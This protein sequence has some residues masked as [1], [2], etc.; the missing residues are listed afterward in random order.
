MSKFLHLLFVLALLS[1]WITGTCQNAVLKG[2]VTEKGGTETLP[3]ANVSIASSGVVTDFDGTFMVSVPAGTYTVKISYVGYQP[4]EFAVT[5]RAG[6]T[7]TRDAE[8]E[9]ET[10]ILKTATVTSGKFARPLSEET[11]SL[12]V[13]RPGLM[14]S[15]GK[16]SLEDALEK[17]PGVTII[18]GQ[19]NIRG[20]SGF[21][22]GAGSRVLL[23]VD[24]IPILQADA[25]YPNW[26][27]VPVENIAQ[28]EVLK[29]A[30]SALYG[31]SAL[32]GIINVRTAFAKSEPE[33]GGA[34]W[35]TT[36]FSPKDKSLK[37]WG[38]NDTLPTPFTYGANFYHRQRFQKLDLV[39]GG[40]YQNEQSFN[41]DTYNEYGRLNFATRYRFSERLSAG[42][43]GNFNRGNSGSFFY[44]RDL[45]RRF[46]GDTTTLGD[47]NRFRYNLDPFLTYFDKGGN[48]HRV[49][50]RFFAVDN[51]N[52][53]RN[54]GDQSNSSQVIYS[55]YQFQ[56]RFTAAQLVLTAGMVGV[57]NQVF[58]ELYGD[59]TFYSRNFAGYLQ[60]DKKFGDRLN[61]SFGFRYEENVLENPGFRYP[62]GVVPASSDRESKPV[63]R[64]GLN[65]QVFSNTFLRTSWGQGYRYPTIAE[66]YIYT[67]VGFP[68]LPNPNA[69]SE[70][71]WSTELG[72]K[73]GFRFGEFEGFLDIAAFYSRIKDMLEFN[74][75][76][77]GFSSINIGNTEISGMEISLAG[78]GKFLGLP[79]SL[80]TGYTW[81][82]PRFLNWDTRPIEPGLAATQAQLNFNNSSFK[83]ENI[84]KYRSRHTFKFDVEAEFN[85]FNFGIETFYASHIEAIDFI[86]IGIVRG[87][88]Q[89]RIQDT[90]GYLVNNLRVAYRPTEGIKLSL[91][92]NNVLNEDYY[93]RPGLMES[94]RNLTLRLDWKL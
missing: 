5:L 93:I 23:L 84:L 2:K 60:L 76:G 14:N 41:K 73:S 45:D 25:G 29:G 30:A 74:L 53:L 43:Y 54:G 13:L 83:E 18:D 11:V 21:S 92:L 67:N 68:I 79:L 38:E 72:V 81:I 90:N 94:P 27:D 10:S 86:F 75:V 48:R 58:A 78:R 15:T 59:T 65:Y 40:F 55:E 80:L 87:L 4:M 77:F 24:D 64:A 9:I 33:T 35:A 22:Q 62:L 31:S 82:D 7:I 91:L 66:R 6:E 52:F 1:F 50:G 70:L 63:F 32:N 56:R 3:G 20:G 57:W 17:I 36:T 26:N 8:L 12:E 51:N 61:A 47:R 19:A 16:V 39:L 28:V 44:W 69:G 89:F 88:G 46:E 71:G 34:L 85:K 49:L 37:W 42:I